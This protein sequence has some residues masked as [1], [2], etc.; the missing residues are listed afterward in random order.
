MWKSTTSLVERNSFG[1]LEDHLCLESWTSTDRTEVTFVPKPGLA[2]HPTTE[3]FDE[4]GNLRIQKLAP[5]MLVPENG[6][7]VSSSKEKTVDEHV[8]VTPGVFQQIIHSTS[9]V[10]KPSKSPNEQ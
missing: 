3:G 5:Y 1:L 8:I 10:D 2:P 7:K 9:K 6:V 4:N